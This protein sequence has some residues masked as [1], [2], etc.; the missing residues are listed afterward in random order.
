[1]DDQGIVAAAQPIVEV[2]Y[3]AHEFRREDADAPYSRRLM[4]RT[5]IFEHRV[6]AEM[7]IAVDHAEAVGRGTT[8][9]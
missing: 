3:A 9:P 4:P 5:G 6:I 7:R 2:D 8:R 1:M